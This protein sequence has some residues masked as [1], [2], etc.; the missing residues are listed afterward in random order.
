MA[1]SDTGGRR[2]SDAAE[3]EGKVGVDAQPSK[4]DDP[5]TG[6]GSGGVG[7]RSSVMM[8]GRS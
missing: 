1:Y 5:A 7:A 8:S 2:S 6:H 3:D 4:Q